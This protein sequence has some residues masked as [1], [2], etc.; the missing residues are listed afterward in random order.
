MGRLQLPAT[1]EGAG[2]AALVIRIVVGPILAYHGYQKLD[3]GLSGFAEGLKTMGIPLPELTARVVLMM[4]LVGGI[5]LIIGLLTRLW[6]VLLTAQFLA[7][8]FVVKS[9]VGLV[10]PE[11][12]GPGFELDLLIAACALSLVLMGPG[13]LAVDRLLHLERTASRRPDVGA[14]APA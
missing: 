10:A 3:R 14:R 4:E 5:C 9:D 11:G 2:M 12:Q 8:P 13:A 1:A 7:I 6:S